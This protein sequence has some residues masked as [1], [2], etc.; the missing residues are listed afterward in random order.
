MGLITGLRTTELRFMTI[1]QMRVEQLRVKLR[2]IFR[3]VIGGT[4]G[5]S[6]ADRGKWNAINQKARVFPIPN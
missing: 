3:S 5:E 2:I 1:H 4:D 6:K